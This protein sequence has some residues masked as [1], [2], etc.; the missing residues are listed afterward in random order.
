VEFRHPGFDGDGALKGGRGGCVYVWLG[1]SD[2]VQAQNLLSFTTLNKAQ[3][4]H[5][6]EAVQNVI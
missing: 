4:R 1:A 5:R 6:T 2:R 3:N